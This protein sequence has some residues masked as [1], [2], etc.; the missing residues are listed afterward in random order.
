MFFKELE[1]IEQAKSRLREQQDRILDMYNN[2]NP[3]YKK[4]L[5]ETVELLEEYDI[6]SKR[7]EDLA[8]DSDSY[9]V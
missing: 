3:A 8:R 2:K 9:S 5:K 6:L 7:F 1:D 4:I